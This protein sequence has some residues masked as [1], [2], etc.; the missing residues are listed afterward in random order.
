MTE[1]QTGDDC[2]ARIEPEPDGRWKITL[3]RLYGP[4]WRDPDKVYLWP[5]EIEKKYGVRAT[6]YRRSERNAR[7]E[8]S[9]MLAKLRR[10][11]ANDLR[12]RFEVDR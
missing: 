12:D 2:R 5:R 4:P 9:R 7:R 1:P 11:I 6:A 10:A 8:A 3:I